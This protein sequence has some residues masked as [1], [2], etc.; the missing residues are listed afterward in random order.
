MAKS[1]A[2]TKKAA[3]NK[4]A[5]PA[6]KPKTRKTAVTGTPALAPAGMLPRSATRTKF[7]LYNLLGKPRAYYLVE[8][9]ELSRPPADKKSKAVAHSI[10]IVDRSGSMYGEIERTKDTLLR[11]LTLDE[12]S[13]FNLLVTL[14]SYSGEGDVICHFDR[15]PIREIMK[16]GSKYQQDIQ[17]IRT[18]GLTCI[19]QALRMA[20]EKVKDGELTAITLH[21]DGYANDPSATTEAGALIKTCGEMK[22]Q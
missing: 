4:P 14:I 11:V 2:G 3:A 18:A 15:A 19:S 22:N 21:S 17:R 13:Q 20:A 10:I 6:A 16:K 9:D 12:Y 1:T 5:K 8:P 7:T